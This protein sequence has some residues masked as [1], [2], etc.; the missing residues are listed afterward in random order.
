[1]N[2]KTLQVCR[3]NMYARA[4]SRVTRN[5]TLKIL[6]RRQYPGSIEE[7]TVRVTVNIHESLFFFSFFTLPNS[8][9]STLSSAP[10]LPFSLLQ[11]KKGRKTIYEASTGVRL[12]PISKADEIRSS[13]TFRINNF[14]PRS[15]L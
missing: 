1:M 10:S 14:L 7:N 13:Q 12:A 15:E 8:L 3:R 9:F 5:S 11:T 6:S 2:G 4:T